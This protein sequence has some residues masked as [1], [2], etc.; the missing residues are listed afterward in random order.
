[1]ARLPIRGR[2]NAMS[3]L[4]LMAT[5]RAFMVGSAAMAGAALTARGGGVLAGGK[6]AR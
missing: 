6:T 4:D 2:D 5:R 3:F 1:M